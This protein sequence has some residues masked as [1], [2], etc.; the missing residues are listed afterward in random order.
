M[1]PSCNDNTSCGRSNADGQAAAAPTAVRT[2]DLAPPP[3]VPAVVRARWYAYLALSVTG[4]ATGRAPAWALACVVLACVATPLALAANH[5]RAGLREL[6]F[7]R[8][9]ADDPAR[10]I[11][12]RNASGCAPNCSANRRII[13]P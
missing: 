7:I 10:E 12:L 1:A 9:A 2:H 6:L 5:G 11:Q 3:L 13:E 8:H 4:F